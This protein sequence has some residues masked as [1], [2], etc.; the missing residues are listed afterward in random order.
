MIDAP[1]IYGLDRAAYDAD[2]CPAPSLNASTAKVMLDRSP[3]HAWLQH[4]R[5]NPKFERDRERKFDLGTAAHDLLFNAGRNI[6]VIEADDYKTKAAR[7]ARDAA[8]TAGKMPLTTDQFGDV[9]NMVNAARPQLAQHR[10]LIGV[11]DHGQAEA[12]LIWQDGETWCRAAV[13]WMPPAEVGIFLDYKTTAASA[14]PEQWARMAYDQGCDVQAVWYMRG[15]EILTGRPWDCRFIVQETEPPYALS[16][17]AL[18]PSALALG[19]AK[20]D[21]ALRIWR[22][23]LAKD[24]W[25]GYPR[26]TAYID[27][28]SWIEARWVDREA[29][30]E[31]SGDLLELGAKVYAPDDWKG[32]PK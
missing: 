15:L 10:D 19:K 12:V 16:V 1:G 21:E 31:V 8:L 7:L 22:W 24:F 20:T 11:L 23:C 13:D 4:P 6:A 29:R 2:P 25:P 3:R 5:L 32:L 9:T 30:R 18:P 28:P 14:N 17:C 26:E 27:P